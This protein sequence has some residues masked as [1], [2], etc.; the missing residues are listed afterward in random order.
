MRRLVLGL[1]LSLTLFVGYVLAWRWPSSVPSASGELDLPCLTSKVDVWT[2]TWGIPHIQAAS[3]PDAYC[4][5][6]FLIARERAFQVDIYRRLGSGSL[7]EI[8]GSK[9]L[10]MDRQSRVLGYRHTMLRQWEKAQA[11]LAPEALAQISSYYAGINHFFESGTLPPEY[12]LLGGRPAPVGPV[13]GLAFMGYMGFSFSMSLKADVLLSVLQER[14]PPEQWEKLR[15]KS[16]VG[17]AV[18]GADSQELLRLLR[19]VSANQQDFPPWDGSNSW[20]LAPHRSTSGQALLGNDPHIGMA[21]PGVWFEAHLQWPGQDLYG[22]FL[23]G[24]PFAILGHTARHGW[25]LTMSL[26]DDMDF[27]REDVDRK[28]GKVRFKNEWVPLESRREIIKVRGE[29]DQELVVESTP[30][31]PLVDQLVVDSARPK[32]PALS[33]KWSFYHPDNLMFDV[34]D[35]MSRAG[36]MQEFSRAVG[37]GA[38]PGLNISY[39]DTEGHIGWWVMGKIPQRPAGSFGDV[40]LNGADGSGPPAPGGSS[41]WGHRHRQLPPGGSGPQGPRH[42]RAMGTIGP[43]PDHFP[44]LGIQGEMVLGGHAR[45]ADLGEFR[46]VPLDPPALVGVPAGRVLK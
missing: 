11:K 23:P 12:D 39:A 42:Y 9:A 40:L 35:G 8:L 14:F 27:Y 25:A 20:V 31:G 36:N 33:M 3:A 7:S 2:D 1:I 19:T 15:L 21:V 34:L 37:L 5:L 10:A 4:A 18:A 26:V 22:H 32:L 29:K 17:R 28:T 46:R 6:G 38:S 44:S 16:S 13:D 30:H 24:V 45:G 43:L 41:Q